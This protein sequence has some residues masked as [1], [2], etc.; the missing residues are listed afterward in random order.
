MVVFISST[1]C[2]ISQA[3]QSHQ[4]VQF[5]HYLVFAANNTE[6]ACAEQMSCSLSCFE[7]LYLKMLVRCSYI[8]YLNFD[9]H[10]VEYKVEDEG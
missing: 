2:H 7:I 3:L 8:I 5:E 9:I 10:F 6:V 4:K 1:H